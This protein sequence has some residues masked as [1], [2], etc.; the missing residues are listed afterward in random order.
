MRGISAVIWPQ[1]LT[2]LFLTFDLQYDE[3]FDTS[4]NSQYSD[5]HQHLLVHAKE[6]L[7]DAHDWGGV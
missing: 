7:C 1:Q 5:H 4:T 6:T 2:C 3:S